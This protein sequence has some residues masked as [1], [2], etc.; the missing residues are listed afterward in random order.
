MLDDFSIIRL[1]YPPDFV[2]TP[3]PGEAIDWNLAAEAAMCG[4]TADLIDFERM[5]EAQKKTLLKNLHRKRKALETQ[6]GDV[7]ESLKGIDRC[8]KVIEKK[9]KRRAWPTE[10]AWSKRIFASMRSVEYPQP[11][12]FSH[13]GVGVS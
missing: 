9:A 3:L 5:T 6:L 12:R 10:F 7:N 4:F 13:A 8:L 2:D 11:K 1:D